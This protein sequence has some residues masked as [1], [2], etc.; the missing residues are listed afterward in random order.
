MVEWT[1]FPLM[2]A[3]TVLA[4]ASA[5][6]SGLETCLLSLQP[7]E[8]H[9]IGRR[10][11]RLKNVTALLSES[12]RQVH[13]VLTLA[14]ILANVPL[15]VGAMY[16]LSRFGQ[17]L[18]VQAAA[19]VVLISVPCDLLPKLVALVYG[20][21]FARPALHILRAMS[22]V[23]GPLGRT[24]QH[25]EDQIV[26]RAVPEPDALRHHPREEEMEALIELK[27]EE[28][29]LDEAE[30]AILQEIMVLADKR[31]RDVITP[32]VELF[33]IPDRLENADAARAA[34]HRRF[35]RMPVYAETTDE[36]LGVLD[37]QEFL[38]DHTG[39]HYT[40]IMATPSFIP[41]TLNALELFRALLRHPRRMA[42]VID[43][44][45]GTEG[46]VTMNNLTEEILG[47]ALPIRDRPLYIEKLPGGAVIASGH[48]HVQ[49]V[50]KALGVVL[51]AR[52]AQTVHQLLVQRAGH[53]PRPGAELAVG[54]ALVTVRRSSRKRVREALIR[55]R[56]GDPEAAPPA[57]LK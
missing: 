24:L 43:E 53:V 13:V 48:A 36:I 6:F 21:R 42:V 20:R 40:E 49:D 31:A 23:L 54:D 51:P 22:R 35:R 15:A 4:G 32:R 26:G 55:A 5:L 27:E 17:P 28:G 1:I 18:W 11:E 8:L 50:R 16:A 3:L 2:A 19:V 52:G 37:V 44:F 46:I 10:S 14:D 30:A 9:K 47:E 38:I 45:G 34:M 33:A 39:R 25:V 41:E 29:A 7:F 57:E 56:T 12:P